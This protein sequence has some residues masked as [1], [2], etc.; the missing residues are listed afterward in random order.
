VASEDGAIGQSIRV[1]NQTSRRE[2]VG[3]VEDERTVRIP[4]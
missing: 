1:V 3:R 4:F 2:L